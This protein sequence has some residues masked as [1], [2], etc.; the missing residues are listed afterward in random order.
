MEMEAP[1]DG[2]RP[3][4]NPKA[5]TTW[6]LEYSVRK[7]NRVKRRPQV[8]LTN[9]TDFFIIVSVLSARGIGFSNGRFLRRNKIGNCDKKK[10]FQD[11]DETVKID[12]F[13]IHTRDIA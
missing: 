12:M 4:I 6:Q 3:E 13:E 7:A 2:L 5:D 8:S 11:R 1:F 10:G 9:L